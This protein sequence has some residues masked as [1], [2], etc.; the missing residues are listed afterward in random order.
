MK[1]RMR[2]SQPFLKFPSDFVNEAKFKIF[3]E[4]THKSKNEFYFITPEDNEELPELNLLLESVTE[5]YDFPKPIEKAQEFVKILK[6]IDPEMSIKKL[7][8]IL[9]K[10]NWKTFDV[11]TL[12]KV[13]KVDLFKFLMNNDTELCNRCVELYEYKYPKSDDLEM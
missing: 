10:G 9:E 11:E 4:Y 13:L 7:Y 5:E 3:A 12:P 2:M 6:E 1:A 8:D